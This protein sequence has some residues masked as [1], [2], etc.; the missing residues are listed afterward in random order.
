MGILLVEIVLQCKPGHGTMS[1]ECLMSDTHCLGF[2]DTISGEFK[3]F[4]LRV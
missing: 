2:A 1:G 3:L 4:N